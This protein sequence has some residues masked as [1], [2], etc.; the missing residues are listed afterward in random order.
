MVA[1]LEQAVQL[2]SSPAGG[3]GPPEGWWRGTLGWP[4]VSGQCRSTMRRMHAAG[5]ALLV[6]QLPNLRLC[7]RST[8]T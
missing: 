3:G 1:A 8:A 6:A 4:S 2:P 7:I 5:K